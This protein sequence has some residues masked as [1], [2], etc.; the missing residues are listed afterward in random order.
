MTKEELVKL[1]LTEEQATKV[2]E[3]YKDYVTKE[4]HEEVVGEKKKL[5][6]DL[7][8]RDEQ[9]E[10]LKTSVKDVEDLKTQIATLQEDN[11][12]KD[13][14]HKAAVEKMKIESAIELALNNS[15][16]KHVD[17]VRGLLKVDEVKLDKDGNVVGLKE[18]FEK[19]TSDE[20]SA[21]LFDDGKVTLKGATPGK[22][23]GVQG[24]TKK[25]FSKMSYKERLEI[26][27]K[28]E[29]LYKELSSGSDSGTSNE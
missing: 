27:N 9:L 16:A 8:E 5:E 24:V 11:K 1:G 25:D 6:G 10:G 4:K 12:T 28:D 19:L 13:T 15:K 20:S 2:L 29:G 17:A 22:S 7:K 14:E 3:G 18:Q 23:G 26:Y 21:F